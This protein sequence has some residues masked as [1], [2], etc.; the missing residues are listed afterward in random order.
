MRESFDLKLDR[1]EH[2]LEE[3]KTEIQKFTSR[4]TYEAVAVTGTNRKTRAAKFKLKFTE[5]PPEMLPVI[6]GD[7]VHN[8]RSALDHLVVAYVPRKNRW[9][10]SFPIFTECPY[11]DDGMPFDN[12]LGKA[13][14]KAVA[15]LSKALL[16]QVKMLQPFQKPDDDTLAFC[17]ANGVEP[18]DIQVL[19]FLSRFDNADKHRELITVPHGLE[20]PV[21]TFWATGDQP[22]GRN[23]QH[24]P[25]FCE[26]CAQLLAVDRTT[27]PK[28]AEMNVE[29]S[30]T[31][32]VAIRIREASG[33]AGLPGTL[34]QLI[35]HA[36]AIVASFREHGRTG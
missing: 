3:L 31:V 1:A 28:G 10:A 5:H 26:D 7:V 18:N 14:N 35:G 8:V 25:F 2:H 12:E 22:C 16:T 33:V 34:E 13:W 20:N 32:R 6:V 21:V 29:V 19:A 4:Q 9:S 17:V 30:G 11:G 27:I 15:G 24:L 36:R 23:V